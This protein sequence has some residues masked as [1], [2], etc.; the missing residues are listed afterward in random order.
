MLEP[1]QLKLNRSLNLT[2]TYAVVACPR[3]TTTCA[4][5]RA[6]R[7]R[8]ATRSSATWSPP[9]MRL[10][11]R[12]E[13]DFAL[14]N[15]LGIRADF[16]SGALNLEQMYNVFPFE[17][18]ITTMFLSGVEVQEMLDFVAARSS[19]RGCR[20]QAQVVRHLLRH[21]LRHAQ[22]G[23]H[24]AARL[25]RAPA[26]RTSCSAITAARPTAPS[27]RD[28]CRPLDPY[29]IYRVAVN[30]YIA[31]GGSGF[32]VLKRNTTK[33]NTGISLRD[34]LIDYVRK[35][36]NRCNPTDYNNIV[37]VNCRDEKGVLGDC[38]AECCCHDAESGERRVRHR[39][40][41]LPGLP[42]QPALARGLRLL[43]HR[44]PRPRHG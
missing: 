40:Q 36:P 2:Q 26:R 16:E 7:P 32:A 31:N 9:P 1:Y 14:T 35:S 41:G 44:L 29:A 42:G 25:S 23:L 4:Q 27:T 39:V 21:G 3:P 13:A 12:V 17:N 34:A 6:P 37:G 24:R 11:K 5:V 20:T 15:S 8:A 28:K 33:F 19:E 10:R 30:D 22:R 18:T 38:T 43:G